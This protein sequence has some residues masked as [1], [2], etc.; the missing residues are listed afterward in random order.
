[1]PFQDEDPDPFSPEEILKVVR[2]VASALSYL[3]ND[4]KIL[5]GDIKGANILVKGDFDEIK[6]CDFGVA[7]S[8][9]ENLRVSGE[10]EES[11]VGTGPFT[12][13]EALGGGDGVTRITDRADVFSLGCVIYEMLAMEAPHVNLLHFDDGE[14]MA[15]FDIVLPHLKCTRPF[16]IPSRRMPKRRT[17]TPSG[18]ARTSPTTWPGWSRTKTTKKSSASSTRAQ[19]TNRISGP[20]LRLS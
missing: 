5:H 11:Y 4:K 15:C 20:R 13:P 17:R 1:M 19:R 16:Q 8:L 14:D 6:L 10:D 3:H 18:P 2:L 7:L 9:D 12:A